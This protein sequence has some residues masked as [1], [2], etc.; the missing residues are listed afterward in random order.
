MHTNV[1]VVLVPEQGGRYEVTEN[2][3]ELLV[4]HAV[5]VFVITV[6]FGLLMKLLDVAKRH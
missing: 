3:S 1:S 6:L 4:D 5:A 2:L